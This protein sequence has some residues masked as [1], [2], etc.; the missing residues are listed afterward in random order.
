MT[1]ALIFVGMLVAVVLL[2]IAQRPRGRSW[3]EYFGTRDG[4]GILKGIIIAPV[5]TLDCVGAVAGATVVGNANITW[6]ATG[7][8]LGSIS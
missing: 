4:D 6:V 7:T 8:R 5:A 3:R 1:D 2:Y